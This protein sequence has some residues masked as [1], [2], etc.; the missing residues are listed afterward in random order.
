MKMS[1]EAGKITIRYRDGRTVEGFVLARYGETMSVAIREADDAA[2]FTRVRGTWVSEDC[3]PVDIR[4]DW[5]Q[6]APRETVSE[7]DCICSKELAAQLIR[8]L[9]GNEESECERPEFER[10]Y[11]TPL[12]QRVV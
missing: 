11:Y 5:H 4:F 1:L 12:T 8:C 6:P 10:P 9:A 7:A 2:L 3:E